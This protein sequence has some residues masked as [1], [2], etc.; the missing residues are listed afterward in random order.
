MLRH[1][2]LRVAVTCLTLIGVGSAVEAT[3]GSAAAPPAHPA[4]S[5]S[6]PTV[7]GPIPGFPTPNFLNYY[8]LS[9]VGYT[10]SEFFFSGTATSYT[11]ATPLTSNGKW[12]V[13]P[14]ATAAYKT[15]MVVIAPAVPAKFSG[16]VIVEWFNVSAGTD[17]GIDWEWAHDEMI[18][19]GDAYVGVSA[20]QV[21]VN[22]LVTTDPARYGSLVQPGDSFSYDIFS[23]AGMAVR[24]DASQL[25]PGLHPKAVIAVGESQSAFRLATYADAV[26]PL[27][28]VYD[29]ILIDSRGATGAALSQS[30][31]VA[32]NT[33]TPLYIRTDLKVPV[34]TFETE[35]DVIPFAYYQSTQPDSRF[36]RLWEV[37]GTTH[38][39]N[40]L[41]PTV[42]VGNGNYVAEALLDSGGWASDTYQ[43]SS[44]SSPPNS[45]IFSLVTPPIVASCPIPFNTGEEHYVF[46]TALHDLLV[47][48]RTGAAPKV[49]PRLQLNNTTTPPTYNLDAN[50]NVLGGIRTPAV[51]APIATL[52]GLP[53]SST[54]P[55]NT[56]GQTQPFTPGQLAALYPTHQDF[57]K[58]WQKATS[59]DEHLGY[60]LPFDANR[61]AAV[62]AGG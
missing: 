46:Q 28:N 42:F 17:G 35:T 57:V 22:N 3:Q 29:A 4:P 34:L 8:P 30:P 38:A 32:I 25:L 12:S 15:R 20:Q 50:G 5:A 14:G 19:T 2:W 49:M 33:P 11:S 48:T 55:C 59:H 26:Q 53:S 7:Q 51:D 36:F 31:Q 61:L 21:G 41:L 40:Y 45:L 54:S 52:S 56:T 58:L 44:M 18:R 10:E 23:Q 6:V 13:Q 16:N 39:D 9:S 37:A 47:W 62:V 60:L 43:F 1:R 24:D 27:V